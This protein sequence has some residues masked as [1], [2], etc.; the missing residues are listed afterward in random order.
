MGERMVTG[1]SFVVFNGAL[2]STANLTAKSSIVEDGLMVQVL[3]DNMGVVRKALREMQPHVVACGPVGAEKPDEVVSIVW[4]DED[5]AF[6]IGIKSVLDGK[7]MDG[8]SSLRIHSGPDM[9]QDRC[10]PHQHWGKT[11]CSN[12]W[13]CTSAS[14]SSRRYCTS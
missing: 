8:I 14:A 3:P 2:K 6:N 4:V 9:T 7:P 11:W 1:A 12:Q 5:K 10:L 13:R